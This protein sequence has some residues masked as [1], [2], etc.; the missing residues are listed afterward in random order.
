[1][2]EVREHKPGGHLYTISFVCLVAGGMVSVLLML[3]GFRRNPSNLLRVFFILWVFAPF[4]VLLFAQLKL[5][6]WIAQRILHALSW[7]LSACSLAIYTYV[8]VNPSRAQGAFAF[9]IFPPIAVVLI[10]SV[11]G[12]IMLAERRAIRH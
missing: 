7:L 9:I 3:Y 12:L 5:K 8:I 2:N 10:L 11:V 6:R 1:M 4:F